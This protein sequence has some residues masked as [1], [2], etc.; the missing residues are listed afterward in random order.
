MRYLKPWLDGD[1]N[2]PEAE[3][4]K[5]IESVLS[6]PKS[7]Y[8]VIDMQNDF[9][10]GTLALRDNPA[11]QDGL[12]LIEPINYFLDKA[13][14]NFDIIVYSLDWHPSDHVSFLSNIELRDHRVIRQAGD[15]LAV[16]LLSL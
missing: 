6:P 8:F 7:A 13:S 3:Y 16:S 15:V 5:W 9:I 14:D 10:T 2:L 11:K 1:Q 12:D 4:K